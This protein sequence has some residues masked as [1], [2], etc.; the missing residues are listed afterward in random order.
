MFCEGRQR[1]DNY[2]A[3]FGSLVG[4]LV[5]NALGVTDY[6]LYGLSKFIILT[7][8]VVNNVTP[9]PKP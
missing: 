3:R 6:Q 1:F 9:S 7:P 2:G 8:I 4:A 5:T